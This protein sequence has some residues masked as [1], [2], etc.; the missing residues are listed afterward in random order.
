M[1]AEGA[2][3]IIGRSAIE[4]S[5]DPEA[6]RE[7]MVEE[8]PQDD[9]P[10]HRGQ[11]RDD[12]RHHRPARD[13]PDDHPRPADGE[14]QAGRAAL[15]EARGDAGMSIA[16]TSRSIC[17]DRRAYGPAT[18]SRV[19]S[20]TAR[21]S[22]RA[23]NPALGASPGVEA[24]RFAT[25]CGGFSGRSTHFGSE[26][27]WASRGQRGDLESSRVDSGRASARG[28]AEESTSG[29]RTCQRREA[30]RRDADASA[31]RVLEEPRARARRGTRRIG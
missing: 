23:R 25:P 31:G 17:A 10:L 12:R 3:N 24:R 1:G 27:R 19:R 5:D 9:R 4:A 28:G 8:V 29:C 14:G 7:E 20:S 21:S 2:V 16:R 11:E 6:T 26:E 18:T 15:E 30:T 22:C 13:P